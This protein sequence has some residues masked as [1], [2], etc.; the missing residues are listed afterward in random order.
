ME[1]KSV[2]LYCKH[3]GNKLHTDRPILEYDE[4]TGLPVL[5]ESRK[6]CPWKNCEHYGRI[7]KD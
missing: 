5:G 7:V 4:F 1:N 3:C 2:K 6:T